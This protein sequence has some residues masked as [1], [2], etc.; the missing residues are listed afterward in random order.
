[1]SVNNYDAKPYDNKDSSVFGWGQGPSSRSSNLSKKCGYVPFLGCFIGVERIK[2]ASKDAD[3]SIAQRIGHVARGIF[4]FIPFVGLLVLMPIDAVVTAF[5]A[6]PKAQ[7]D[8]PGEKQE[9][10]GMEQSLLPSR[11]SRVSQSIIVD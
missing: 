9:S 10:G 7:E 11:L 3:L 8:G 5:S 1:M 6:K 2:S 4:E